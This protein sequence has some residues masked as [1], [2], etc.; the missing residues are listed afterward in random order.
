MLPPPAPPPSS[1]RRLPQLCIPSLTAGFARPTARNSVH[2]SRLLATANLPAG[3]EFGAAGPLGGGQDEPW[4]PA[5]AMDDLDL[6]DEPPP[7]YHSVVLQ[8]TVVSGRRGRAHRRGAA[9]FGGLQH[10]V[11]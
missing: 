8:S 5:P 11:Q 2:L 7:P 9:V 1:G 6:H 4:G 10:V 3:M